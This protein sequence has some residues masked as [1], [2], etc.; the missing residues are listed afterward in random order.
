VRTRFH[1]NKQK[2]MQAL[3]PPG[4]GPVPWL[5]GVSLHVESE[6]EVETQQMSIY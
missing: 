5:C 3:C 1:L 6:P 4:R 2:Q